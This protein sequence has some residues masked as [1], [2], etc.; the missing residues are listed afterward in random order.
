MED[1]WELVVDLDVLG[2]NGGLLEDAGTR[3]SPG[4]LMVG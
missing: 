4:E 2:R 3:G 1:K